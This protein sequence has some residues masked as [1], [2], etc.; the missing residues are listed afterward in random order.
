MDITRREKECLEYVYE[1]TRDGW[2][3]T[4][5]NISDKL[6]V[7]PPT[8]V[9]F[10]QRL[11]S[12]SMIE[13]GRGGYRLTDNGKELIREILRSHRIFETFLSRI[14][15]PLDDACRISS[16]VDLYI[17]TEAINAICEHIGHPV[18]CPHGK[19]IPVGDNFDAR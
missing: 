10:L 18:S 11:S 6:G 12:L 3:A 15:V 8:A 19:E 17:D 4:L 2:P 1:L 7:K 9:E 5:K 16:E 14:G 13:K